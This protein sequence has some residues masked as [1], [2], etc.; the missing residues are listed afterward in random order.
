V[1]YNAQLV[2]SKV[3][4][5]IRLLNTKEAAGFLRVSEA[6]IRRWG[7]AGLLPARRVGRR[8]ERRF[9]ETDLIAFLGIADTVPGART[10]ALQ[11]TVN[12]G[13]VPVPLHGHLCTFY[14]SDSGRL[15]LTVPF[16]ADGLRAGQPCFLAAAGEA[17]DAHLEALRREPRV[18]ID[19]AIRA[20]QFVTVPGPGATVD[21]SLGFWEQA[22]WRALASGPTILRVVGEMASERHGFSSDAEMLRYEVAFNTLARRFPT[23]TLCQ[24]DVREFD[25]EVVFQAIKSHPDL[26]NLHLGSFLS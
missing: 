26:L 7:D 5:S 24:Y 17:L 15:R 18:D 20:G 23:V 8:R 10:P 4:T 25:G 6:S 16:F 2:A 9:T 22:W 21:E 11:T 13:G 14:N 3:Q 1:L 12:V 19:A